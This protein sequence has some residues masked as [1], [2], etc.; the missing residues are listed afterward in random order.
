MNRRKNNPYSTDVNVA[1]LYVIHFKCILGFGE[2]QGTR[3]EERPNCAPQN[4]SKTG[5][6]MGEITIR[7]RQPTA[8]LFQATASF[9][10]SLSSFPFYFRYLKYGPI[11]PVLRRVA[12]FYAPSVAVN[13]GAVVFE[14]P[15]KIR[16]KK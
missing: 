16:S 9:S 8:I 6:I 12:R 2:G 13:Y 14:G 4:R 10:Y 11:V 7:Q 5:G 3:F 15:R 1:D